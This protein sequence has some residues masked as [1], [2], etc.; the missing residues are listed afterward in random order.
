MAWDGN[1]NYTRTNGTN[2]GAT[3][4]ADDKAA[5][6][7]I[8]TARH[9]THDQD[10]ATAINACLTQNNESKPTA[11]FLPNVDATYNFGSALKQWVDGFFSG[12]ITAQ[13]FAATGDT[14]AG[15]N[16]S[17]GYT[18]TE[19]AIITGQ[20][21]TNDVTIKNDADADVFKIPTGTTNVEIVGNL[22]AA[23]FSEG[24]VS[25]ANPANTTI[26]ITEGVES[27]ISITIPASWNTYDIDTVMTTYV[28][29]AG[30]SGNTLLDFRVRETNISGSII[31]ENSLRLS[32]TDPHN[33]GPCSL[34]GYSTGKTA[35][36]SV[37]HVLT[38]DA[39]GNS[40]L[41]TMTKIR[42]SVTATRTS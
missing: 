25:R 26:S 22:S 24:L 2:T 17:M 5:A 37:D 9:D 34:Y 35:T 36:G 21:S 16:A 10:I 28:T 18:A 39:D 12:D 29:E 23:N 7:K 11:H 1:G 40:G 27:T 4:W 41:Y 6:V 33:Q 20:G 13:T 3:V 42:W 38:S 14:S 31:G 8:T 15:D 32:D 30:A 19:G